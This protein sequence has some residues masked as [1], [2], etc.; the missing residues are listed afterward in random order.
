MQLVILLLAV[1]V[2]I[3]AGIAI[4]RFAFPGEWEKTSGLI[5]RSEVRRLDV[6]P[7]LV[8][9]RGRVFNYEVVVRYEYTV[10]SRQFQSECVIYGLPSIFSRSDRAQECV[11]R[12]PAGVKATVYFQKK[13]PDQSCLILPSYM[14][15]KLVFLVSGIFV[16][17]IIVIFA[18]LRWRAA[19]PDS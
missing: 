11:A 4:I 10:E 9:E 13:M 2:V 6:D 3:V 14:A 8:Q 5:V 1:G 7:E 17:M 16:F 15:R 18:L 19:H 12:F